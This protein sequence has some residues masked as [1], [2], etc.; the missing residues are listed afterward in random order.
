MR[1]ASSSIPAPRS[2]DF[3][4]RCLACEADSQRVVIWTIGNGGQ[5]I[6]DSASAEY[7]STVA[8]KIATK[9]HN[10]TAQGFSPGLP[11]HELALQGRPKRSSPCTQ[12]RPT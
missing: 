5:A 10:R 9:W 6:L 2:R 11:P 3:V 8:M 4:Q 12:P 1:F 7:W